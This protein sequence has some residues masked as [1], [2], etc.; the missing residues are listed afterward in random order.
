[1]GHVYDARAL[2]EKLG[3]NKNS[4]QDVRTILPKLTQKKYFKTL[5][6]GYARGHEAKRYVAQVR[7]FWRIL[8]EH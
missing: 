8:D 2:A 6:H 4:W 5:R 7:S 3:L 1:M